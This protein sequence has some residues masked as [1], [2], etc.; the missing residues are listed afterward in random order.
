[1]DWIKRG[2]IFESAE[3]YRIAAF[4]S[5]RG[6]IY[7]AFAP[8]IPYDE[9]KTLLRVQYAIGE[10]VPQQRPLLGCFKDPAAAR[11]ACDARL[12][13]MC[14]HPPTGQAGA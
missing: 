11:A 10:R 3:G 7:S 4:R 1:M 13:V 8:A 5:E 12:S 9:F 2:T 6:L 14:P